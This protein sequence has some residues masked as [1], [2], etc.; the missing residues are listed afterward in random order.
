MGRVLVRRLLSGEMGTPERV[1]I[2]SRDEA[3][4]N[5]LRTSYLVSAGRHPTD[6]IIYENFRRTLAFQI[7]DVR[8]RDAV[9]LA[10]SDADVVFNAAALKQVPTC[11]YFP[12]EAIRT[13][14]EGPW[15]IITTIRDRRLPVKTVVGISTDKAAKP[16][17]V[18]GMTKA[19]QERLFL[20]ANLG[21]GQ[22]RF[23]AVRYGNVLASRGSVVPLFHQQIAAGGPVT[24]TDPDMTRFLLSLND[25]VDLIFSACRTA[26]PGETYVPRVASARVEDIALALIGERAIPIKII[27]L[28]PGE[29]SHEIMVSEEEARRTIERDGRYVIRPI[30]P[31]LAAGNM[32]PPALDEEYTS[33]QGVLDR[34]GVEELFRRNRLMVG[35]LDLDDEKDLLR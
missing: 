33:A 14:V 35:D 9:S 22:T 15:N 10:L 19:L 23:I 7:G 12:Y 25:A 16:I 34:A 31:E 1:T 28:R 13:N 4:Q 18:M 2:M 30:L 29:K 5:A 8:D 3:K 20:S 32:G 27:G 6:E 26:L 11:E 21:C 17:N 24:L